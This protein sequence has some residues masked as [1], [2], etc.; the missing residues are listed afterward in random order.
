MPYRRTFLLSLIAAAS[1]SAQ[2]PESRAKEVVQMILTEKF[3]ALFELFTPEMKTAVTLPTLKDRIGPQLK[4][5]GAPKNVGE[6]VLKSQQGMTTAVIPVDFAPVSLNFTVTLNAEGRVAGLLLQ[7]RQAEV[8]WALPAYAKPDQYTEREVTVGADEWK[9]PATLTL[10]KTTTPAPALVLVHGSGP[11][12]RDETVG[13][14]KVFKD[15]ATGLASQG[16]AVLRYDKRTK[17]Y[18]ARLGGNL[19][20]NEETVDDAL[21]AVDLLRSLPE[22]DSKR[23]FVLG[24]SLGGYMLP[25]IVKRANGLAGAIVLAG[26]TRSIPDLMEEQIPYLASLQPESETSRQQV[27]AALQQ[28][29]KMRTIQAAEPPLMGMPAAYLLDLKDYNPAAL[30]KSTALPLLLLQGER[31]YQVT[32]K[33]FEGWKTALQ[34]RANATFKTYPALNHLFDSGQGKPSPA[35]YQKPGHVD[36]LVITDIAVWI[37]KPR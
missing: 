28:I 4:S 2:P 10:P 29:A 22:I 5:L 16:I 31:D 1:L 19:T 25:R 3:D 8:K 26:N 32:L 24:H 6:P 17:V 35:E 12:D 27:A 14:H 11:N 36:P 37:N 34:G 21:R 15:L 20:V 9:L 33:D 18:G 7:P 13:Q 30:L 23:I